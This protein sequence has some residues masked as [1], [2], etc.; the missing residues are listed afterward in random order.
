MPE[1]IRRPCAPTAQET[2]KKGCES[3]QEIP[4]S[5]IDISQY[6]TSRARIDFETVYSSGVRFCMVR[7]GW[8]GYDGGLAADPNLEVTITD[9]LKSG[10]QVGLYV[11]SY[12]R[13]EQAARRAAQETIALA[14]GY[15]ISYPIAIDV[16]D[17]RLTSV[18]TKEEITDTV[19]AFC[20][21][22]ER[23]GYYAMFYTYFYFAKLYLEMERL[24]A[25]DFWLADYTQKP[26]YQ[27]EYGM[28]QY[29]GSNGTCPGVKGPCDRDWAYKDY[30]AIIKAAGLN[31]L[32]PIEGS[33]TGPQEGKPGQ[34]EPF[35]EG[36]PP[37]QPP[38]N[39]GG[40]ES[41]QDTPSGSQGTGLFAALRR[42]LL[43]IIRFFR[44]LF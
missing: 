30:A 28:W 21:E 33:P 13:S 11:Y 34:Q 24:D 15:R 16:E 4:I 6:Q 39:P 23:L 2:Q 7:A 29:T 43:R 17:S 18:L 32:S 41:Q 31:G 26:D 40:S 5:G 25:Y 9:A 27:G 42:L 3:L 22:V 37:A 1:F 19:I 20:S 14:R 8:C 44:R 36:T 12:A 10:V 35:P 38:E